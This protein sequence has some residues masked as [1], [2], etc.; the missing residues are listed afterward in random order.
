MRGLPPER[1]LALAVDYV[2]DGEVNDPEFLERMKM[3]AT[4]F[5]LREG[6]TKIVELKLLTR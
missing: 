2:E 4:P 3:S 6:D 5:A 1:Y